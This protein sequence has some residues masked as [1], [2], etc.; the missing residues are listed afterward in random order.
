M[1]TKTAPSTKA[2]NTS[3]ATGAPRT[4]K[5]RP[6][7]L[8]TGEVAQA[9]E[10]DLAG[11]PADIATSGLAHTALALARELDDPSNSATAKS[12]CARSLLDMTDRMRSLLP[13]TMEADALDD[14]ARRREA[15][16]TGAAA[17]KS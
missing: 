15:R 4:A 7:V 11:Y 10:R 5:S 13:A 6:V 1:T 3:S 16:R 14:L 12:M 2:R 9:V 17:S 8:E